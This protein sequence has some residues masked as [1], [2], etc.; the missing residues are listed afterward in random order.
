MSRDSGADRERL[1]AIQ[2][3][4]QG[5]ELPQAAQLAEAA[6]AEGLEHPLIFN[7]LALRHELAGELG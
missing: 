3:S 2:R 4:A 1:L 5:G 7:V 6:L